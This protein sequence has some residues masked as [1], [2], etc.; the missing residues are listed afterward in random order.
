MSKNIKNAHL[1][2]TINRNREILK[3]IEDNV[4]AEYEEFLS[5]SKCFYST[6]GYVYEKGIIEE[7]MLADSDNGSQTPQSD[8]LLIPKAINKFTYLHKAA[9]NYSKETQLLNQELISIRN[10]ARR[11]KK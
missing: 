5:A 9:E 3:A 8:P 7:I 11:S 2:E 1:K 4:D 10:G 6:E